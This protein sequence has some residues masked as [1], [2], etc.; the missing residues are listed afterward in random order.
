MLLLETK[1]NGMDLSVKSFVPFAKP[2]VSLVL[3]V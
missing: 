2:R 3:A 1:S